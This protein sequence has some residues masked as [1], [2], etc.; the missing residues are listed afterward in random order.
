[1]GKPVTH[2]AAKPEFSNSKIEQDKKGN[3]T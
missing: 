3:A 2:R 1:M